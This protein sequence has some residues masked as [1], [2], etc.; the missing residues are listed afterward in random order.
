M[1]TVNDRRG[2]GRVR[3]LRTSRR[4]ATPGFPDLN[5]FADVTSSYTIPNGR[6][7]PSVMFST[8]AGLSC[9]LQ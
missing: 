3:L 9:G 8:P 5:G 7:N 2:C 4:G 1:G 6:G